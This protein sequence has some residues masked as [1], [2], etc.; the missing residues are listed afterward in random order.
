MQFPV[1]LPG[2]LSDLFAQVTISGCMTKADRYGLMAALLEEELGSEEKRV[3]DRLLRAVH[4]GRL[5]IAE[6]VSAVV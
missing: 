1:L 6:E 4:R 2:A 5:A 3:I